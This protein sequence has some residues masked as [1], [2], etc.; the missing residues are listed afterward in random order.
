MARRRLD[1]EHPQPEAVADTVRQDK[2]SFSG[3]SSFLNG[4][5]AFAY[6]AD[7]DGLADAYERVWLRPSS[8]RRLA[9]YLDLRPPG[10]IGYRVVTDPNAP[11]QLETRAHPLEVLEATME[12]LE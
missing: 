6:A 2:T 8:A 7:R 11:A 3:A 4:E 1:V 10:V 9:G 12:S 5:G